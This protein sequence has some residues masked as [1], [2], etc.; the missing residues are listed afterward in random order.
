VLRTLLL[1]LVSIAGGLAAL[2][3][4]VL[5]H[6]HT[7]LAVGHSA[8]AAA[9]VLAVTMGG[10]SAGSV[11]A[12]RLLGRTVSNRPLRILGILEAVIGLCGFCL[13][14][15][16]RAI[17]NADA[18]VWATASWLAPL[19]QLL[20][21]LIVVGLPT[22]AMGATIPVFRVL[23]QSGPLSLA[24]LYMLNVGGAAAGVLV[25][26][27][28]LLPSLGVWRTTIVVG[29]LNMVAG[30]IAF[31][32]DVVLRHHGSA[33]P[34]DADASSAPSQTTG[35]REFEF[36]GSRPGYWIRSPRTAGFVTG[37]ATL[38]LE[39][40]WF[41]SLRAAFQ[42][43]TDS[44]AIM[45]AAVLVALFLGGD[46]AARF[47]KRRF[48]SPSLLL[49]VAGC[50]VL[51]AA[52]AIERA[53]AWGWVGSSWNVLLLKRLG[54]S[55]MMMGPPIIVLGTV[56]PKILDNERRPR[57]VGAIYGLNSIGAVLGALSCG[58]I[59]LPM[60]GST[61][62]TWLLGGAL[63]VYSLMRL[64]CHGATRIGVSMSAIGV[65]ALVFAVATESG[66]GRVR[67]QSRDLYKQRHDVLFNKE[68]PDTTVSVV[69]LPDGS[70][71]LIID[72]FQTAG[73]GASDQFI[74]PQGHYM[75]W[76]GRLPMLMHP[77]PKRA[78]VICLGTGQ[79][80]HSVRDE[81]PESVDLVELSPAV[82][83]ASPYFRAN[84]NVLKDDRVR[85]LVMDGR[86][87]LKRTD[88]QYDVATLE[89]MSPYFAGTN[90]L[91]S[92]EFYELLAS[93]MRPDGIAAQWLPMH[94]ISPEDT[95]SITRTFIQVFPHAWLWV[96]PQDRTGILVGTRR[97]PS[98]HQP[99][100][101]SL[102]GLARQGIVRDLTPQS[103]ADNFVLDAA[104]LATL[105]SLGTVVTDDNQQLAYGDGRRE[106]W[107][108]A[109]SAV[110]HSANLHLLYMIRQGFS[111][112]PSENRPRFFEE[113]KRQAATDYQARMRARRAEN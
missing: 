46:L 17:A 25:S 45:L 12:G 74:H 33:V 111:A 96:D 47:G 68:G 19:T 107:R 50:L 70:R 28:V 5:W 95:A 104:G 61:R 44:F 42:A 63:V 58:F 94:L 79:T 87:W 32:G 76:M 84:R 99:A 11:L 75:I 109:V 30:L 73:E 18:V 4:Q 102:P 53:D 80:V 34:S 72:G 66:V 56:L 2:N 43:T 8:T 40:A 23:T 78:L 71:S 22:L 106:Y 85:T 39:V 112:M 108:L 89:P 49:G 21:I 57:E 13:G 62:T 55:F 31:I 16:Y 35:G 29:C 14:A 82:V 93:R 7:S 105:G 54:L 113:L 27:F 6:H 38:V 86:T 41:R 26:A 83:A 67:V 64:R 81:Q 10:L 3:W 20:G 88:V 36:V 98:D 15:G 90:A 91:Y 100:R 69:G 92:L 37:F 9:L 97:D 101:P 103:V 59:F 65:L 48:L 51:V 24:R 1:S 77:D 60:V 110:R 52:P